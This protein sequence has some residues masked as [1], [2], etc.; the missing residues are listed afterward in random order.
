M[1]SLRS[2]ARGRWRGPRALLGVNHATIS[3][4]ISALEVR[5]S[6]QAWS[7][8]WPGPRHLT[9]RGRQIADLA[10]G[11]AERARQIERLTKLQPSRVSGTVRL[12]APPAML[13]ETLMPRLA[14]DTWTPTRNCVWTLSQTAASPR[15]NRAH[16][17]IAIRSDRAAGA[18][19]HRPKA[20]ANLLRALRNQPPHRTERRLLAVHRC[21]ARACPHACPEMA[22]RVCSRAAVRPDVERPACPE[23]RCR[24]RSRDRS[25]A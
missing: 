22:G 18:A 8:A 15:W 17:D 14:E 20:G 13:S 12:S 24:V 11:M 4:R 1:C 21:G 2:R 23:V 9:E 3:R 6:A 16:A 7:G 10:L 25:A 19:K 5:R